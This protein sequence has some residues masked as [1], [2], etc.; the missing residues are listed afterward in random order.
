MIRATPSIP[1]PDLLPEVRNLFHERPFLAHRGLDAVRRAL[2]MLRGLAFSEFEVLAALEAL[3][4]EGEV[5][6]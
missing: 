2:L 5:L 1:E 6:S 3:A 4:I